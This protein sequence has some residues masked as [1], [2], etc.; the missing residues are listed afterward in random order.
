MASTHSVAV[1]GGY[2]RKTYRDWR[3]GE[4]RREWTILGVLARDVSDLSPIPL[5]ECLDTHPP[6]IAMNVLPGAPLDGR[7]GDTQMH[8]M[9][10]ALCA[11]WSGPAEH[12]PQRRFAPCEALSVARE[13][14]RGGTKPPGIAGR[15]FDACVEFL[16][17]PGMIDDSHPAVLGHSDPNLANYLWDGSRVRIVDFEDAGRSDVAYEVATLVEHLSARATNW[18]PLIDSVDVDTTRL[19]ASRRLAASLWLAGLLPGGPSADR[20]PSGTLERQA[21]HV[22][23]LMK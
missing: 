14:F 12:L 8:A 18:R 22:L 16:A 17:S 6:W 1:V 13:E 9:I 3:R 2:V 4:H 20:N 21:E 10:V 23:A 11:L 5:R 15:A 7:L 19:L